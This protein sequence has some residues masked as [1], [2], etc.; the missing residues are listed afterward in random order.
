MST[1]RVEVIPAALKIFRIL[2]ADIAGAHIP[3]GTPLRQ[4][5]L[6]Q[7]FGVSQIPVRE[8]LRHLVNEGLAVLLPNRGVQVS[9]LR[10]DAVEELVEYRALIEGRLMAWALPLLADDDFDALEAILRETEALGPNPDSAEQLRLNE[11]FHHRL[12]AKADKPF[13]LASVD[14]VRLNLNRYARAAWRALER[15]SSAELNHR[16]LLKRCRTGDAADVLAFLDAHIRET[17][18]IIVRFLAAQPE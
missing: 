18:Q 12:Y 13:F 6:A 5:E 16:E 2:Q 1:Q 10:I 14:S 17:G 9:E 15:D 7:R 4:E 8:A 11:A 3:P